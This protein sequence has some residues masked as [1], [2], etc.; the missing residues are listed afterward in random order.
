LF[1]KFISYFDEKNIKNL[2]FTD[3]IIEILNY[4]NINIILIRWAIVFILVLMFVLFRKKVIKI[5][6]KFVAIVAKKLKIDDVDGLIKK[7][8]P[9]IR[10]IFA[11]FGVWLALNIL[12]LNVR[13]YAFFSTVFKMLVAFSFFWLLFQISDA[14][15]EFFEDRS[16]FENKNVSKT[17][18]TLIRNALKTI[19]I[20][21]GTIT[22]IDLWG[23]NVGA[24][25]TGL[26]LGGLA[27]ALAAQDTLANFFGSLMIMLDRPFV[28]GDWILTPTVE[29]TVEDI[30]FRSTKVRTF[31]QAVVSVPNS[32]VS[33]EPITNWTRMGK[34]RV[35]FTLGIT[36]DTD[37][38]KMKEVTKSIRNMLKLHKG[39]HP[40]TIMV[41]FENFGD[42]SLNIFIYFF[43]KTTQWE[44]YLEVKEQINLELMDILENLDVDV[45]FPSRSVY[46][47]KENT[48]IV[49]KKMI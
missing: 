43:T 36:Y 23:Y 25:L 38:K 49:N 33:N 35:H 21:I 10:M 26:G 17:L 47:E 22:I 42:S 20:I 5:I 27:F 37:S 4:Y 34:R 6:S 8:E 46:I 39:V 32:I 24:L 40:D 31:A 7:V 15:I 41:Y 18:F 28:I 12:N 9:P 19:I 3:K 29:G 48:H 1:E 14:I 13:I 30:G 11:I 16:E 45:A 2:I 44:E